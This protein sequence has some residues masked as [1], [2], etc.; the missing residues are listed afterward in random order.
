[1]KA[2]RQISNEEP[3]MIS[4]GLYQ[5]VLVDPAILR[6]ADTVKIVS[7]YA[8]PAMCRRHIEDVIGL[9]KNIAV[10][11]I[12]GMVVNDGIFDGNHI[13]FTNLM[14]EGHLKQP[15]CCSYV[16]KRPGV[17]SKLYIWE[18]NGK[19]I[20]AYL[21]SANYSQGAFIENNTREIMEVCDPIKA[22]EYF[23][24]INNDSIYCNNPDVENEVDI[25][26]NKV[27]KGAIKRPAKNETSG[28]A[29]IPT[30]SGELTATFVKLSLLDAKGEAHNTAG[31]NWGQRD[32]RNL[33]QAYIPIPAAVM[34]ENF[35]PERKQ[36]FTVLTDDGKAIICTTAQTATK[37]S[38]LDY[39]KAIESSTD[40]S[41]LGEYFRYRLGLAAGAF[42]KT[43][44]VVNYGRTDVTF[45][46]IDS[47][48]YY[49]DFSV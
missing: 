19:P 36:Q 12:V 31:L 13:A 9:H 7:G 2:L 8:S 23:N 22:S 38:P 29:L 47:E 39:Y 17:H 34:R 46:K 15:V 30:S 35:F 45:Y 14:A 32:G 4:S 6:N 41:L 21:G 20:E 11:L 24:T 27:K 48:T 33:N 25:R 10:E 5:S 3:D 1:M 28:S 26:I 44:D 43:S 37:D 42:V 40:N 49:M 16:C 18:K